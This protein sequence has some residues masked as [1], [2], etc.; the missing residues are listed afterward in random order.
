MFIF[1]Y[2][3]HHHKS[4]RIGTIN[5]FTVIINIIL[6]LCIQRCQYFKCFHICTSDRFIIIVFSYIYIIFVLYMKISQNFKGLG[7]YPFCGLFLKI[8][9]IFI[10]GIIFFQYHKCS[11][12]GIFYNIDR[13]TKFFNCIYSL[14]IPDINKGIR[15]AY[16]FKS[17]WISIL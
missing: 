17:F 11:R 14:F 15:F 4:Q 1:F 8:Y 7:I 16:I 3:F 2:L 6:I 10:L 9:I 5:N 12:I 13:I